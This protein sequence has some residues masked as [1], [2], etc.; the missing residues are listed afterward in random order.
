M[1]NKPDQ[2]NFLPLPKGT[3]RV[4]STNGGFIVEGYGK[5]P[6]KNTYNPDR[7]Q[8]WPKDPERSLKKD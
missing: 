3:A 8:R 2:G 1:A 7:G 4:A 5:D 6:I